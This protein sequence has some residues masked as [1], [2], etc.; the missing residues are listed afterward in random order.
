MFVRRSLVQALGLFTAAALFALG[1]AANT[2]GEDPRGAFARSLGAF[3]AGAVE[4]A[5]EGAARR[6]QESD[7]LKVLS[8]FRDG[9]GQTLDQS[10]ATW[11]MSA[12]EYMR[13]LPFRDGAAIPRCRQEGIVLLTVR[14]LPRVYVCPVGVGALRSPFAETQTQSPPLAEAMVIHEMLHTLGLGE[15]PP[16][17]EEITR[18]VRARCR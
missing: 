16:S 17:S 9:E 10:L 5:K 18:R 15:N 6:L 12:A 1:L 11:G 4:R 3:D 2:F 7:C 8:E 14:G 13:M